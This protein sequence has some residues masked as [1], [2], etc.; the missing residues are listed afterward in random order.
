MR[1]ARS[2]SGC[3]C[4]GSHANKATLNSSK[5][6]WPLSSTSHILKYFTALAEDMCI[7]NFLSMTLNSSRSISPDPSVSKRLKT[8]SGGIFD[9]SMPS[10]SSSSSSCCAGLSSRVGRL[11]VY[12][13]IICGSWGAA[14]L[15]GA[16]PGGARFFIVVVVGRDAAGAGP[17]ASWSVMPRLGPKQLILRSGHRRASDDVRPLPSAGAQLL[18][19]YKAVKG[20]PLHALRL[21][22]SMFMHA[23]SHSRARVQQRLLGVHTVANVLKTLPWLLLLR[24]RNNSPAPPLRCDL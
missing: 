11:R 18:G 12:R 7:F 16:P 15:I 2:R 9:Q 6:I 21:L 22:A 13:L 8:S 24:A 19:A 10:S 14:H 5:S 4:S 23:N 20:C 1:S 3:R 17:S